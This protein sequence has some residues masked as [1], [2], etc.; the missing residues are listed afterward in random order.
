MVSA[1]RRK[2]AWG[3]DTNA[4]GRCTNCITPGHCGANSSA[5][6]WITDSIEESRWIN[7]GTADYASH[8]QACYDGNGRYTLYYEVIR[9][10]LRAA[11][12][13]DLAALI[14]SSLF[15]GIALAREQQDVQMCSLL[16]RRTWA[17]T[18][19]CSAWHVVLWLLEAMRRFGS[20][21]FLAVCTMALAVHRGIDAYNV[22]LNAVAVL[23]LLEIDDQLYAHGTSESLRAWCEEE[24]VV[25]VTRDAQRAMLWSKRTL[26]PVAAVTISTLPFSNVNQSSTLLAMS[27]GFMAVGFFPLCAEI[28]AEARHVR[29]WRLAELLLQFAVGWLA[30]FVINAVQWS[31]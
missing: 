2:T 8:C 11:R 28:A 4:V 20:M 5:A 16:R 7:G 29:H 18:R 19:R 25:H 24:R 23:F 1:R 26:I 31:F 30:V 27:L 21:A 3:F 17:I 13:T 15:V 9:N 22:T 12:S 14:M 10:N 6:A